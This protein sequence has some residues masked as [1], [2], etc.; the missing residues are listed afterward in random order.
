MSCLSQLNASDIEY[1]CK[2]RKERS[3]ECNIDVMEQNDRL[4]GHSVG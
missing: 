1:F 2:K 4:S 3:L